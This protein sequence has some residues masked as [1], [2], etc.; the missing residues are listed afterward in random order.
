VV[1]EIKS[2]YTRLFKIFED[3]DTIWSWQ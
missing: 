3:G 2:E 1:N